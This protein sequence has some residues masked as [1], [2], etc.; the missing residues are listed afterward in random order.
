MKPF[1][2]LR[3]AILEERAGSYSRAFNTYSLAYK[4]AESSVLKIKII[5][6]KSICL[7]CVGNYSEARDLVE[8]LI[9]SFPHEPESFLQTALFSIRR[10]RT[11]QAKQILNSAIEKFPEF[12]EFYLTLAYLYK[13]TERSNESI[14]VLKKALMQENLSNGR[15]GIRRK[16]IWAELGNLYFER[17]NYN[18]CIMCMKKS[19]RLEEKGHPFLHYD[20]LA[21]SYLHI[22]DYVSALKYIDLHLTYFEERDPE[23]HILKARIH[24]K[25]GNLNLASSNLLEAY[26][27]E[28]FLRLKTQDMEDF[29]Q[30][31]K[32]GFFENIENV[33]IEEG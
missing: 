31:V 15:G 22:E 29:S 8:E 27:R 20:T 2:Y 16:D 10:G 7:E 19:L 23:D 12:L 13:E 28:G 3:Q 1:F 21:K 30:L 17:N 32:I 9:P 33:I 24:A 18:S 6:K 11:K 25:L 14:Q 5:S 26:D 4:I